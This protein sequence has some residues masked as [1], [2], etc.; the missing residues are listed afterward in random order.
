MKSQIA[1]NKPLPQQWNSMLKK[2]VF[3]KVS[4]NAKLH[5]KK[6]RVKG[7][8]VGNKSKTIASRIAK[9]ICK[10]ENIIFNIGIVYI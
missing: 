7:W 6:H 1:D 5:K 8:A 10:H 4:S 3:D 2:K 9:S